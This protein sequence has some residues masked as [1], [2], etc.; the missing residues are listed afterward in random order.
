MTEAWKCPTEDEWTRFILDPDWG[1]NTRLSEHLDKCPRCRFVVEQ[2]R[3]ELESQRAAWFAHPKSGIIKLFPV[4]DEADLPGAS[5][6]RLAAEGER[7]TFPATSVMLSSA[8]KELT[9]R[10]VRDPHTEETWLFLIADD[11]GLYRNALVRVFGLEKEYLADP[12]GRVNLG[13][14]EWPA[15]DKL[16]AE[17]RLP[18][19]SFVLAP[20]VDEIEGKISVEL[21]SPAGDR[22]RLSL[23]G[24]GGNRRLEIQLLDIPSLGKQSTINVALRGKGLKKVLQLPLAA[25]DLATLEEI[26]ELGSLEIFLFQ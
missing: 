9:L 22:L 14:I 11:P 26:E 4:V 2:R 17:V 18:K 19:A 20:Y 7:E 12:Q 25:R 5:R 10:A 21:S 16:T 3:R 24:E 8:D 1:E 6:T 15:I 13:K 23:S